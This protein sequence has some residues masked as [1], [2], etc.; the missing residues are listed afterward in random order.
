MHHGIHKLA[1]SGKPSFL[2]NSHIDGTPADTIRRGGCVVEDEETLLFRPHY[3]ITIIC[4]TNDTIEGIADDQLALMAQA[5]GSQ[6]KSQCP[7]TTASST[8]T[9][10]K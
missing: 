1:D 10:M 9:I 3:F 6:L 2:V 4:L 7:P 5:E 8:E